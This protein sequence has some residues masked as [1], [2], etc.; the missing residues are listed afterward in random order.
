[1]RLP[2]VSKT[3]GCHIAKEVEVKLQ[4]GPRFRFRESHELGLEKL[5][6]DTSQIVCNKQDK[7]HIFFFS[8]IGPEL[9]RCD[10]WH[11]GDVVAI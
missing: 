9:S 7:R 5:E 1:M 8:T 11:I 10:P 6:R 3:L 4:K 2:K